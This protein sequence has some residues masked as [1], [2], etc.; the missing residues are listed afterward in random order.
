MLAA[1]KDFAKTF[2]ESIVLKQEPPRGCSIG[3]QG[4]LGLSGWGF[5]GRLLTFAEEVTD[6][7]DRCRTDK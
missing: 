6:F 1:R 5:I 4:E 3:N 7:F 2:C